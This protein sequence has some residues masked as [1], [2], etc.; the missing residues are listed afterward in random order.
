MSVIEPRLL[1]EEDAANYLSLSP[2]TF[3][4]RVADGTL[5]AGRKI[6]GCRRWDKVQL[7]ARIDQWFGHIAEDCANDWM[8]ALNG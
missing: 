1:N 6:G 8:E 4:A 2:S 3:R 7:D 5:P